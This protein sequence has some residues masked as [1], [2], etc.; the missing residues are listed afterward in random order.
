MENLQLNLQEV[1][2]GSE[3]ISVIAVTVVI[4]VLLQG[5]S[6]VKLAFTLNQNSTLKLV[7]IF[8]HTED[9]RTKLT[10]ILCSVGWSDPSASSALERKYQQSWQHPG[11]F[12]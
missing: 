6:K 12:P 8:K 9:V 4:N 1:N 5:L 10:S 3:F 11:W 2:H 7:L